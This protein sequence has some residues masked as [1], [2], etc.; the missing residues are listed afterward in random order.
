M[1]GRYRIT[2]P[3]GRGAR[4]FRGVAEASNG[5]SRDVAIRRMPPNLTKNQ[6][7]LAMMLDDM[8]ASLPLRH[9]NI[10]EI[11]DIAK[12]PDDEYFVVTE[13]VDGCDLKTLVSRRKHIR[14]PQVLQIVVES[15]KGLAHAHSV[16]VIHRDVS[17]RAVLLGARGEVKLVDFGLAKVNSQIEASDPGIVKGKFSYLSP[18]AASGLDVDHRADVFAAGIVL[19]ELVAGRRLFLGQTDYQTVEL[20]REARVAAIADLDP[21]LDTIIRKALSRDVAARFRTAREFGDALE[22]YALSRDIKL[23]SSETGM[24]V[25]DVKYE[26]DCERSAQEIDRSRV[27][28]VQE[29]VSHMVS[30]LDRDTGTPGP[31]N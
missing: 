23:T 20:I 28:R 19:W 6:R 9:A 14:V 8:R 22:R 15:C 2:E 7:F 30:I 17:P 3:L 5:P 18:E 10:V 16:D 4:V 1:R 24:L 27:A 21:A 25:G 13:Y 11:V 31:W 26:V 12:T 29:S